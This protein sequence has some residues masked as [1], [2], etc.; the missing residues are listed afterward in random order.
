MNTKHMVTG[1]V[2]LGVLSL[3]FWPPS[4]DAANRRLEEA[5]DALDQRMTR[6]E[7]RGRANEAKIV[8]SEAVID[9][10]VR[11][12]ARLEPQESVW[13]DLEVGRGHKWLFDSG[14]QAT[15]SFVGF[16]EDHDTPTFRVTHKT[17]DTVVSLRAGESMRGVDDRGTER[18]VYT[19]TLHA[20]HRDRTGTA[21]RALVSVTY[22]VESGL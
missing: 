22:S 17:L 11:K 7:E 2:A 3:P 16:A 13:L 14:E 15:V 5:V 1:L 12:L 19:S 21:K 18:R 9:E 6:A 4:P 20:L 10:V 8:N